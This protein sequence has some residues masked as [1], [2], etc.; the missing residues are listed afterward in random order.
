MM[1]AA[2][3]STLPAA[4][5]SLTYFGRATVRLVTTQKFVVYIDPYA[6][7][8]NSEPADL[9]LV[10]HGH[11]DHN[12][13]SSIQRKPGAVIVAPAGAVKDARVAKEKDVFTV[14][15]VT[16]TVVP[17]YNKNHARGEA[18]GYVVS[19]DGVSV[20]HAG[21]TSFIPEM[22]AL[23]P[24]KLDY[25]LLPTDGFWNMGG[26]EARRCADV[27]KARH[28]IA[29]HSSPNGLYDAALAAKLQGPDVIP[30]APGETLLLKKPANP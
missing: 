12:K 23:A 16:V 3:T 6:P 11:D 21:D 8:A 18:V 4:E 13:L 20:Y 26:A 17:A 28:V 22:E 1:I 15:P 24:L 9:V 30:L 14:G 5:P 7:G 25:A 2:V 27:L 29:I 10:T 19:L